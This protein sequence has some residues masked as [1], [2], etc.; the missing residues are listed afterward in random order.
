[1]HRFPH[2]FPLVEE[3]RA[4]GTRLLI[5]IRISGLLYLGSSSLGD[6]A[7]GKFVYVISGKEIQSEMEEPIKW[8]ATEGGFSK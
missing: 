8:R 7:K 2:L 3:Q 1:M 5:L 6:R 4:F